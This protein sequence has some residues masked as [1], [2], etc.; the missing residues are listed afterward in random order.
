MEADLPQYTQ[1]F[2]ALIFVVGLMG[3]GALLVKK[4]GLAGPLPQKMGK[5]RLKV[6]EAMPLD[7]RRKLVLIQRDDAQHLVILGINGETIVETNIKAPKNAAK[8]TTKK[9]ST[10]KSV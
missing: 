4:L 1:L 5:K 2:A 8:S 6:I 10:K 7:A 3:G 9:R